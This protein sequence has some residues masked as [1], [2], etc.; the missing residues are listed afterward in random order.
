MNKNLKWETTS[1]Y[2][3]GVDFGFFNNKL[4][5]EAYEILVRWDEEYHKGTF[6]VE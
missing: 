6:T 2:N 4:L 3:G 5:D 1:Q